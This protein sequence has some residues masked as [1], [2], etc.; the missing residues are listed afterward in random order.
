MKKNKKRFIIAIISLIVIIVGLFVYNFFF[1]SKLIELNVDEIIE[2]M[3]N[4]ES[5][6]LCVSQTECEHCR[7][8]KPKLEKI[9]VE[10]DI[11]LF[12]IDIN[13]YKKEEIDSFKKKIT[14][15]GSTPVTAFI[16][17]GE[18]TSASTRIN[19]DAKKS[20]VIEKL[21]KFGFI[22]EKKN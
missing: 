15:D 13:K 22:E 14:F 2:K 18:E 6:V 11:D 1:K 3:N 12:Y 20:N 4:K 8:Y 17:D 5:F 19:G 21:K 10:Y 16:I 7:N 9:A